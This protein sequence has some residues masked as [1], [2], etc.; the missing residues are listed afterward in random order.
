MNTLRTARLSR[1]LWT[2]ATHTLGKLWAGVLSLPDRSPG[3]F[4]RDF[5]DYPRYPWY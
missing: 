1:H 4:E 2:R 5:D 3:A